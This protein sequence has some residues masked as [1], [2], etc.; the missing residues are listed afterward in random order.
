MDIE[1]ITTRKKLTKSLLNQM[2]RASTQEMTSGISLGFIL[3]SFKGI[4]K[5][6]LIAY[7]GNY[8]ILPANYSR[9]T[10]S[11]T[12]VAGFTKK[13]GNVRET[14]KFESTEKCTDWWAAYQRILGTTTNQ[15]Y[16]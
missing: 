11:V 5:L 4:P 9:Y 16:I 12:R 6:Y 8:F 13:L 10:A 1:I 3:N 14:I 2:R 7:E 15:I